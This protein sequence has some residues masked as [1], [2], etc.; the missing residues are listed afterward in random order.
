[1]LRSVVGRPAGALWSACHLDQ[2]GLWDRIMDALAEVYNDGGQRQIVG[3]KA[4]ALLLMTD[5]MLEY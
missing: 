5:G 1:M 2:T 3:E 4:E